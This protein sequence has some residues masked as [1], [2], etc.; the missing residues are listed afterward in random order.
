LRSCLICLAFNLLKALKKTS[1]LLHTLL[2]NISKLHAWR[3][4]SKCSLSKHKQYNINNNNIILLSLSAPFIPSFH[5]LNYKRFDKMN[6]CREGN[7][8][9]KWVNEEKE[10]EEGN[11]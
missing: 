6:D 10:E 9:N 11:E 5:N 1:S 4:L 8:Q 2:S 7:N 3:V